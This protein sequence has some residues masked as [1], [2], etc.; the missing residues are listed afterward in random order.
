VGTYD[1]PALNLPEVAGDVRRVAQWFEQHPHVAHKRALPELADNPRWQDITES[2]GKWLAERSE[3]DIVVIFVA[4]HGEQEGGRAYFLGR[5]SPQTKLAGRA[6]EAEE[7]GPHDRPVP[8][9][10]RAAGGER[11]RSS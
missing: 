10:Q 2:L 8:T 6:I 11:P 9:S 5:N 7:L 3:D 1:L 4:S